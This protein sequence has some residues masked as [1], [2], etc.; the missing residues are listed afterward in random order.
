MPEVTYGL[1]ERSSCKVWDDLADGLC[2]KC[3]DRSND[4]R[5]AQNKKHYRKHRNKLIEKSKQY[6]ESK[7]RNDNVNYR[8]DSLSGG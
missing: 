2:V 3:W 6:K 5:R 8:T 4:Q 1:C 7:Q